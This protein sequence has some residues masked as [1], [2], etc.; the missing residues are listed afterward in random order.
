MILTSLRRCSVIGIE[1]P[2]YNVGPVP[3][4]SEFLLRLFFSHNCKYSSL[5]QIRHKSVKIWCGIHV[6]TCFPSFSPLRMKAKWSLSCFVALFSNI[7]RIVCSCSGSHLYCFYQLLINIKNNQSMTTS[8]NI[9]KI[10]LMLLL[11]LN[12]LNQTSFSRCGAS[13]NLLTASVKCNCMHGMIP[14]WA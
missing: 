12:S 9:R 6:G 4:Q 11:T 3:P 8:T 14:R 1:P 10:S 5:S 13:L 7:K 2:V